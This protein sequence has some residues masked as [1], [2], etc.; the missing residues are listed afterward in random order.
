MTCV[1]NYTRI[2]R[3][4]PLSDAYVAHVVE[5]MR[6]LGPVEAKRMFGGWGLYHRGTCF[7]IVMRETLYL[8]T[9]DANRAEFDAGKLEAFTFEKAGRTIVTG[10][11]AAPGEALEDAAA[12]APWARGAYAAALRKARPRD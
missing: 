12:M 6:G 9:D 4:L 1:L 7:A 3:K 8:K 5:C 2:M 10:Y 11:R